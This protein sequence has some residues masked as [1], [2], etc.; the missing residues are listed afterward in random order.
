MS[1]PSSPASGNANKPP[2]AAMRYLFLFLIGLVMGIVATVMAMRAIDARTDHYPTS[3]MTVMQAHVSQLKTSTTANRCSATD[4]LPHL[5]A[6]RT[7]A[8]DIEPAFGDMASDERFAKHASDLRATLDG[9]LASP[10]LN[11]PDVTSALEKINEAC[12][13]CH[14]DFKG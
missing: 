14:N 7:V 11:C 12:T 9:A 10:P 1:T 5:Q 13:A 8:N 6:L 2:S 3:V 4:V